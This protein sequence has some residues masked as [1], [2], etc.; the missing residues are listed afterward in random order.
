MKNSFY[1]GGFIDT[2]MTD[3]G[4]QTVLASISHPF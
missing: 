2:G 3:V 4:N 1:T